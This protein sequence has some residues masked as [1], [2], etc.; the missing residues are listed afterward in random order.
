M[1]RGQRERAGGRLN[2]A[3]GR[4][5]GVFFG[6]ESNGRGAFVSCPANARLRCRTPSGYGVIPSSCLCLP[7]R[8][9]KSL[10]RGQLNSVLSVYCKRMHNEFESTMAFKKHLLKCP[11][12]VKHASVWITH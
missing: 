11:R 12:R 1:A 3:G 7:G 9:S 10:G 5:K 8:A 6:I 2:A 4:R